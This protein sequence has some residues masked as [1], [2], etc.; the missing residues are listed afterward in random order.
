MLKYRIEELLNE[1]PHQKAK[2]ATNWLP[3]Q[4]GVTP[5]TWRVWKKLQQEDSGD[6]PSEKLFQIATFFNVE[7][8]DLFT[9]LPEPITP[10]RPD[11]NATKIDEI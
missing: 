4:L 6:I 3:Q 1:I 7:P 2:L 8:A 9:E 10:E 5:K 11:F